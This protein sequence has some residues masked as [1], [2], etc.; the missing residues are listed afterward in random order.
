[1][2]PLVFFDGLESGMFGR[3]GRGFPRASGT[4]RLSP[5]HRNRPTIA[6]Y[7]EACPSVS[8]H[9]VVL[10]G[11]MKP[12]VPNEEVIDETRQDVII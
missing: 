4:Y 3:S 7:V 10:S 11:S 12:G 2:M 1:M 5:A 6:Y 8:F 9:I